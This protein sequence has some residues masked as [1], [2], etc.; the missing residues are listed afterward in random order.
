MSF[1]SSLN[2]AG[3]GNRINTFI[4]DLYIYDTL[5][6]SLDK[7]FYW[8]IIK[9]NFDD[10]FKP[11]SGITIVNQ[12]NKQQFKIDAKVC[13]Q[14]KYIRNPNG[15]IILTN[16]IDKLKTL[17]SYYS[18]FDKTIYYTYDRTPQFIIDRYLK[19]INMLIPKDYIQEIVNEYWKNVDNINNVVGVHI[20][21]GDFNKHP[22]RRV[23]VNRFVCKMKN[24]KTVKPKT[25]FYLSTDSKVLFRNIQ[26]QFPQNSIITYDFP[27]DNKSHS[28]FKT[29]LIC[30]L[31][32]SKPK[33]LILTN[34]STYSQL[35]WWLGGCKSK[36]DIITNE[37]QDN[38]SKPNEAPSP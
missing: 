12:Y 22:E 24:I 20:R 23:D 6:T 25:V 21:Q 18:R 38:F 8:P 13:I 16:E 3:L 31:I 30:L 1:I 26:K 29:A 35:A 10:L 11:I 33:H 19:Y 9:D 15:F 28:D 5:Y 27:E 36:V 37:Y 2:Y 17:K 32:L 34:Y 14:N 7:L 4:S